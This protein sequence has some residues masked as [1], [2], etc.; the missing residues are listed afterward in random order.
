MDAAGPAAYRQAMRWPDGIEHLAFRAALGGLRLLPYGAAEGCLRGVARLVGPV[1]GMRRKVVDAQ[2][3]AVYPGLPP[4]RRRALRA[5]I[6]DHL[7]RTAAE[8][9]CARPDR[10]ANL[11]RIEPGWE[12]LDRALAGGRG[13]IVVTGH[14]GNFELGGRILAARYRL[15]DVVKPQRNPAFEQDLQRMRNRHGIATVPMDRAGRAVLA[16]LRGGGLVSLLVDQDAGAQGLRLDFLGRPA[17]TWPG[18]ARIALRTGCPVVPVA[19]LRQGSGHVFHIG[20]AITAEA[21]TSGPEEVAALMRRI[22]A[23]VEDFIRAC[24]EQWFWVHRR[25]KGANEA[26]LPQADE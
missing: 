23:G 21:A 3:A 26:R 9:F 16:H 7:G 10:L 24:P 12:S 14:L 13:A 2:L 11:V 6:Y 8:V 20:E 19:I 17:S 4:R 22:S 15:L 5:A 1:G 18:A 25:W